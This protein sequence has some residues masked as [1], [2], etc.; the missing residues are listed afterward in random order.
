MYVLVHGGGATARFWDRLTPLLDA[1]ALAVDLPGRN[2][3]PGDLATQSVDDEVRSVVADIDAATPDGQIVLVAHS[4]G[5]LVV[6]GVIAALD[7]QVARVVLSAASVPAEGGCG[8]DCMQARHREGVVWALEQAAAEG[9]VLTTSGAPADPEAFRTA[10]GGDPLDDDTLAYVTDPARVVPD[11]MHHY[12][13]PVHWSQA[14]G[15]PVT[16]VLNERDRPVPAAL[17]EEMIDRLPAPP[18]VVRLDGGHIPAVT[19]AARFAEIVVT[20]HG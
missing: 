18:V 7:G 16:Y 8:L 19:D 14:A 17:Q 10:Y 5:G 13:Q 15:V 1:P 4:S 6:P 11:T 2:G 12:L 3:K 20:G 9:R